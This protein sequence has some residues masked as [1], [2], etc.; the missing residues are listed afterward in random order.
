[1]DKITQQLNAL[2]NSA[3]TSYEALTYEATRINPQCKRAEIAA[4]ELQITQDLLTAL[5][6]FKERLQTL[7]NHDI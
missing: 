5:A 7:A 1:M 3:G 2:F 4:V 6:P